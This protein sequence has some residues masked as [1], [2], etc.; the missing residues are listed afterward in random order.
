M[1]VYFRVE[2]LDWDVWLINWVLF[3][4]YDLLVVG[5]GSCVV[6]GEFVNF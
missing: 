4:I 2:G 5:L 3:R 1:F 6:N